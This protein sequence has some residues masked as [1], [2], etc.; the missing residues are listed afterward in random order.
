[1][2][3]SHFTQ[4]R[5]RRV[6][7]LLFPPVPVPIIVAI[8]IPVPVDDNDGD[9]DED[10]D[11]GDLQKRRV[12]DG[13]DLAMMLPQHQPQTGRF[14]TPNRSDAAGCSHDLRVI[15]SCCSHEE[16]P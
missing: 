8:V 14:W 12:R 13:A 1:M 2:C 15:L 7:A 10:A 9:D 3:L 5:L 16:G 6:S 11:V 4:D